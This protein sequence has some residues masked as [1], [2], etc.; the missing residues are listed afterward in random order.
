LRVGFDWESVNGVFDKIIE[1]TEEVK[2]ATGP[3]DEGVEIGD[4]IFSVVKPGSMAQCRCRECFC[5]PP[6]PRFQSRF[7]RIE[8]A[9]GKEGGNYRI[10]H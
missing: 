5:D 7:I 9:A 1:E 3:E 8:E 2:K 6:M 4:L 10:L